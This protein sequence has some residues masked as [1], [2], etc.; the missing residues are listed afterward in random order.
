MAKPDN[1]IRL[2]DTMVFK[3]VLDALILLIF[4]FLNG[5]VKVG[6]PIATAI[7]L[8]KEIII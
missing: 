6:R 3:P 4:I 8:F 2:N 7:T 5:A 1:G